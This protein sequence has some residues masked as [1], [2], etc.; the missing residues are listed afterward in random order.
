MDLW[1]WAKLV[2]LTIKPKAIT[3]RNDLRIEPPI[4]PE[5][6]AQKPAGGEFREK[7]REKA[8]TTKSM[9]YGRCSEFLRD[10]LLLVWLFLDNVKLPR[11]SASLT[12]QKIA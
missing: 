4:Q 7:F 10:L 5:I 8:L 2:Q 6:V 3:T 12:V 11:V 9:G 1:V